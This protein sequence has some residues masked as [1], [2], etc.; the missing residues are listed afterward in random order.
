MQ[1]LSAFKRKTTIKKKQTAIKHTNHRGMAYVIKK[2]NEGCCLQC[3]SA[4]NG[5]KGKKF[6]SLECKNNYHN[7]INHDIRLY[8]GAVMKKLARNTEILASLV[9]EGRESA[10]M[11]ELL[12]LGFDPY[13]LTSCSKSSSGHEQCCCFDFCF[14]RTKTRIFNLRRKSLR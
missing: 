6:C 7:Q 11:D 8:R 4:L 10:K 2:K 3:G 9:S 5:R 1:Y 12:S 13:Y 14:C